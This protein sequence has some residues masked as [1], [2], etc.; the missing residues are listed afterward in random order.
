MF[1]SFSPAERPNPFRQLPGQIFLPASTFLR[2]KDVRDHQFILNLAELLHR[3]DI[4]ANDVDLIL[5]AKNFGNESL[6][7]GIVFD[8]QDGFLHGE[9]FLGGDFQ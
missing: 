2:K 3:G 1:C 6:G 5:T 9:S 8:E 7:D 4:I